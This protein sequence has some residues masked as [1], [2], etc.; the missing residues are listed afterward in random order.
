MIVPSVMP[1]QD[2]SYVKVDVYLYVKLAHC[3]VQP[4]F[5]Y[6]VRG[7]WVRPPRRAFL[8]KLLASTME[9]VVEA[10]TTPTVSLE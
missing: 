8:S 1:G 5:H 6:L 4:K 7:K 2:T 3:D 9:F 10:V